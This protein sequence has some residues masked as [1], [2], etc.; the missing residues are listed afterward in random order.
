MKIISNF[1]KLVKFF[2][3]MLVVFPVNVFHHCCE[4]NKFKVK[5]VESIAVGKYQLTLVRFLYFF[6]A[7]LVFVNSILLGIIQGAKAASEYHN[8]DDWKIE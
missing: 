8:K 1:A 3:A 6:L 7:P 2:I 5:E 4:Y